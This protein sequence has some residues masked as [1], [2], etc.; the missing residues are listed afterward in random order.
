MKEKI[1]LQRNYKRPEGSY[2]EG[3][4][5]TDV[6]GSLTSGPGIKEKEKQ[7]VTSI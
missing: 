5:L 7:A 3:M 1:E 4:P 6:T 2:K